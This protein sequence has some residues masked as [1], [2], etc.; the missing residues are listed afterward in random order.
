MRQILQNLINHN[1]K[2]KYTNV[3]DGMFSTGTFKKTTV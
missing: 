2:S 1:R 3:D